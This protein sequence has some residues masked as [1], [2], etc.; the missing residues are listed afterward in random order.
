MRLS[1]LTALFA[2]SS[3]LAFA[4]GTPE[5]SLVF[6]FGPIA[7]EPGKLTVHSAASTIHQWLRIPGAT[8]EIRRPASSDGQQLSKFMQSKDVEQALVDAAR[9]G[10]DINLMAFLNDLD[11]PP[12]LLP[13]RPASAS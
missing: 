3:A 2:A 4:Q 10:R 12:T 6:V 7:E 5:R 13:A 8:A 9:I 1:G 11:R